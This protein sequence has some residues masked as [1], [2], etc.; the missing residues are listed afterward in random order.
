MKAELETIADKE[1]RKLSNFIVLILA[2]Y[3]KNHSDETK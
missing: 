1:M 2:D 3:L